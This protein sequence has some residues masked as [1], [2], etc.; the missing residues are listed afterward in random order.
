MYTTLRR[1]LSKE[2]KISNG[3]SSSF[4]P[5][6]GSDEKNSS[7]EIQE[8]FKERLDSSLSLSSTPKAPV[9]KK[10]TLS[11]TPRISRSSE[12]SSVI[13]HEIFYQVNN[14]NHENKTS[15]FKQ[16]WLF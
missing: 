2:A 5:N 12:L 1:K 14:K 9:I 16:V 11:R 10:T 13:S 6:D 15:K 7:D 3:S 8:D 4:S